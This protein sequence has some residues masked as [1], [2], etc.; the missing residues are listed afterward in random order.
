MKQRDKEERLARKRKKIAEEG[1][2]RDERIDRLEEMVLAQDERLKKLE[3]T[4]IELQ[5]SISKSKLPPSTLRAASTLR[6]ASKQKVEKKVGWT[7]QPKP[8]AK[9]ASADVIILDMEREKA[10]DATMAT[11]EAPD[12]AMVTNEAPTAA[13]ATEE[14]PDAAM[15]TEE[16]AA[17][18]ELEST[19]EG[20]LHS[21][22]APE[23]S[24]EHKTAS[25]LEVGTLAE[26][27]VV[28]AMAGLATQKTVED[29]VS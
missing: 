29:K 12:A 28:E 9:T 3:D 7:V 4:M 17:P 25:S 11:E 13:M 2:D 26:R 16:A 27:E 18:I 1:H 15:E 20:K 24:V 8:V 14:A 10:P 6:S 19:P 21:S 23:A 5:A 22:G